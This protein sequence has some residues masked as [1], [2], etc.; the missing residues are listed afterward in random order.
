MD[1]CCIKTKKRNEA[2][3]RALINRLSRIEGQVRGVK[4][5]LEN[6]G[7]CTDIILQVCAVRSALQSFQS[8]LLS[9][10]LKTCVTE[11]ILSGHGE[12]VDELI[13]TLK[14]MR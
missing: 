14:K 11:D 13:E 3:K 2:E 8:E 6:D 10:H 1:N 12:T 4:N 9:E 5:M 7:Y